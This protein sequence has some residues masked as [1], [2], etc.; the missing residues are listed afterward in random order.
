M[1]EKN[2]CERYKS[3]IAGFVDKEL[4]ESETQELQEHL[5][6]CAD[7]R[8]D[9]DEL[10]N[11]KGVSKQMKNSLLPDMKWDEYWRHLYNRMERGIGWILISIGAIVLLGIAV[12]HFVGDV[13]NSAQISPL[14]K[15]G[16]FALALGFVVLLVSV[17][18]EKLM[19]RKHDKYREIVR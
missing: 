5:D 17:I 2:N 14:E 18:R 11:W 1:S 4:S 8:L 9:L 6:K 13:L 15:V 3:L 12:Y 7:C 10:N 19:V 16:I